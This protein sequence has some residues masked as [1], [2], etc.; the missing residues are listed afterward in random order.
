MQAGESV[1][2]EI[3]AA[4]ASDAWARMF[5]RKNRMNSQRQ[6]SSFREF[7]LWYLGEHAQAANRTLHFIG[8][9]LVIGGLILAAMSGNAWLLLFVPVVGYGFA[10]VGHLVFEH[11]K[12]ATFGHP[13]YSLAADFL[14][15]WHILT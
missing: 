2:L 4:L 5:D 6:F 11:N 3:T 12:P 7:Y 15:F 1:A 9:A 14:M 13:F 8:T 10:W